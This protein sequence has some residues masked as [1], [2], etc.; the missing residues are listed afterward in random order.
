MWKYV[1]PPVIVVATFWLTM[2][3]ATNFYLHWIEQSHQQI[4]NGNV[5]SIQVADDFQKTLRRFELAQPLN[6]ISAS[7]IVPLWESELDE[8]S[9]SLKKLQ[10]LAH[11]AQERAKNKELIQLY[12]KLRDDSRSLMSGEP[13][14]F[15]PENS[16]GIHETV[17]TLSRM[18]SDVVSSHRQLIG[19]ASTQNEDCEVGQLIPYLDADH[20]A[21]R[22]RLAGMAS[23]PP[24]SK[25][26]WSDRS[27]FAT[28]RWR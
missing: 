23:I 18:M 7:A 19:E 15:D 21:A 1:L 28:S 24:P 27:H 2:S 22:R 25:V 20:G 4:L 17:G 6:G 11:S 16:R 8:L 10:S 14:N 26:R 9:E 13:G 12:A 5:A 3:T